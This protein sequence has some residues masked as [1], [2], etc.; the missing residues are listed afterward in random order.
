MEPF[1]NFAAQHNVKMELTHI[2]NRAQSWTESMESTRP[3]IPDPIH[4]HV[5]LT[6][7]PNTVEQKRLLWSGEY[8]IGIGTCEAWA[9]KNISKF[10]SVGGAHF[11]MADAL[12]NPLPA[13]RVYSASAEYWTHIKNVFG[14]YA[15]K[16]NQKLV[17]V[18]DVLWSLQ[19]DAMGSDQSFEDWASD[20][21]Y[22]DDSISARK[23]W[24]ICNDTR[25]NLQTA[26]GRKAFDTFMELE[27][28]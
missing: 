3:R 18:A 4:F 6:I 11:R 28:G 20:L 2:P 22:S 21:G 16:E 8:S 17:S 26:M 19:M 14:R 7:E 13:G 25:R 5:L 24:E 23:I 12:K 10:I 9:K 15:S 1:I 27:E